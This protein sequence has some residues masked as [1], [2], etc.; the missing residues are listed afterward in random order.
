MSSLQLIDLIETRAYNSNNQLITH[1]TYWSWS[2]STN[3]FEARR[4]QELLQSWEPRKR[5]LYTYDSN[6]PYD[7]LATFLSEEECRHQLLT[8][9]FEEVN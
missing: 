8:S 3:I 9:T 2:T 5:E 1:T 4:M 7:E 6:F